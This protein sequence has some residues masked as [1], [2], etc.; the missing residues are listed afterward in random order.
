MDL[1]EF[2]T[3]ETDD[4]ILTRMLKQIPDDLDKSEG[5]YIYDS[6]APS[7]LELAQL[8]ADLGQFLA[9]GFASTTFGAYLD[10]RCEERGVYRNPAVKASGSVRLVGTPGT[11]VAR[12]TRVATAAD[13]VSAIPSLEYE[14]IEDAM[15]GPGGTVSAP[16]EAVASGSAGN[17]ASGR[18]SVIST[19]VNG[20]ETVSNPSAISG[21]A[22]IETDEALLKRYLEKTSEPIASGNRAQYRMWAKEVAGVGDV[23]IEPRWA[24]PDTIRLCIVDSDMQP[25]SEGL[26]NTV[27]QYIDPVKGRGEGK[28]PVDHFVTVVAATSSPVNIGATV[29]RDTAYTL[30]Q[31]SEAF[32]TALNGYLRKASVNNDRKIRLNQVANLLFDV[33]GVLDY[34][35]LRLNS[36]ESNVTL[37]PGEVAV[38]GA[39]TLNE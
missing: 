35:D 34:Y 19:P 38:L 15:V 14:V 29:E 24:G 33:P 4:I 22:D 21:G 30:Q 1:P 28:A 25:A 3:R 39:V 23:Y 37:N 11:V 36:G 17:V 31:I 7:A 27:Q 32:Q 10:L 16:V 5:S 26:V 6:L 18:I 12:A 8:K 13:P 20:I 2:L 9:R